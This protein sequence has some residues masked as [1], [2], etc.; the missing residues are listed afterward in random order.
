MINKNLDLFENEETMKYL[1]YS[2]LIA[3]TFSC[4]SSQKVE[5][6]DLNKLKLF[7]TSAFSVGEMFGEPKK[8]VQVPNSGIFRSPECGKKTDYIQVRVYDI[9][10]KSTQTDADQVNLFF[11]KQT[12]L[13]KMDY[14]DYDL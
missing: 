6:V 11:N 4:S 12:V 2:V 3:F 14:K 1:I 13:C 7:Q 9:G 10:S 5:G 8:Q